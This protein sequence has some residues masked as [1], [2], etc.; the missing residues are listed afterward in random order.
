MKIKIAKRT[1]STLPKPKCAHPRR[2]KERFL[3][4]QTGDYI[5]ATCG[6]EVGRAAVISVPDTRRTRR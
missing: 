5:C 6:E 4:A 2:V 1:A 3:G